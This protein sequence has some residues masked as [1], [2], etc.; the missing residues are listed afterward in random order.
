MLLTPA[1]LL[2]A[3]EAERL[4]SLHHYALLEALQADVFD[5]LVTLAAQIFSLPIAYLAIVDAHQ[6]YYNATYGFAGPAPQPRVNLLCAQ[7]VKHNRVVVYHDLA[8]SSATSFDARAIEY[9]LA[10]RARFYVGAPVRMPDQHTI[11]TL[12]LVDQQPREFSAEEQLLLELL[13]SLVSELI[14]LRQRCRA[15]AKLGE[16]RWALVQTEAKEEVQALSALVRYLLAR[17]GTVI[18][19]PDQVLHPVSRRLEDLRVILG[20]GT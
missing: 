17:Y 20:V 1:A 11:G 15:L 8:T 3:G 2:P 9:S 18:P 7:V 16:R 13:A 12:C 14:V 6:V 4:N 10:Q 5:E 19:V